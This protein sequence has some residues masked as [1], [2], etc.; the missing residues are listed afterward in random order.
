MKRPTFF[1]ITLISAIA[2]AIPALSSA[3]TTSNAPSYPT[4]ERAS[5][6]NSC[7][8]GRGAEVRAV[9]ECT[10]RRITQKYSY[11][12]YR[13]IYRRVEQGSALPETIVAMIRDCR[14]VVGNR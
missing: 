5:F 10:Y 13:T 14:R 4:Q 6:I 12:E 8:Y 3:Q 9:G 11:E 7:A 1:L 2:I